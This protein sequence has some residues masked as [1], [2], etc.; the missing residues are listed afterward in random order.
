LAV[1]VIVQELCMAVLHELAEGVLT[2][3]S[4]GGRWIDEVT[5]PPDDASF[6][7]RTTYSG[8]V[9]IIRN[10][11]RRSLLLDHRTPPV[12]RRP[13]DPGRYEDLSDFD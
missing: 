7:A 8:C 4:D 5:Q 9:L 1:G 6:H 10:Q 2:G 12:W 13:R 11:I 3:N